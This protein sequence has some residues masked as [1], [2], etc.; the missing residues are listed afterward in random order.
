MFKAL[1]R[2]GIDATPFKRLYPPLT[3]LAK[4]RKR[5]VHDADFSTPNETVMEKWSIVDHWQ[6]IIWNLAVLAFY[7]Q[8]LVSTDSANEA[9]RKMLEQ[10]GTA[11]KGHVEFGKQLLAFPDTPPE[12]WFEAL[13][14]MVD[15][16]TAIIGALKRNR[17]VC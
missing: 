5:I 16:L 7:Y 12:L 1:A 10:V 13:Q 2:A 15:T 9:E 11:M 4:R 6:L 8:L 14:K 3:Q 17:M